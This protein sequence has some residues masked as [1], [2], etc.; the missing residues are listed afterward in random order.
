MYRG[1]TMIDI[2]NFTYH[3]HVL[4]TWWNFSCLQIFNGRANTIQWSTM[5][6]QLFSGKKLLPSWQ[7]CLLVRKFQNRFRWPNLVAFIELSP[8]HICEWQLKTL[9]Y[10]RAAWTPGETFSLSKIVSVWDLS[11]WQ[12]LPIKYLKFWILQTQ[13]WWT[14]ICGCRNLQYRTIWIMWHISSTLG[15]WWFNNYDWMDLTIGNRVIAS[16]NSIHFVEFEMWSKWWNLNP[17][18]NGYSL[19]IMDQV[20]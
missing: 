9:I 20:Y 8:W 5:F 17:S 12:Q 10:E 3:H 13:S 2:M 4:C 6:E 11:F 7:P 19:Y 14:L 15:W 18:N 16:C 1:H